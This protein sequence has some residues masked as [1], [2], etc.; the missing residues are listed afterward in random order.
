MFGDGAVIVAVVCSCHM[1]SPP[2]TS[3]TQPQKVLTNVSTV[4]CVEWACLMKYVQAPSHQGGGGVK[5]IRL[6]HV[7]TCLHSFK[8]I[9]CSLCSSNII[10]YCILSCKNNLK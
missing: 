4:L 7:S 6:S 5:V 10:E 3:I 2:F 9:H 8:I 1:S